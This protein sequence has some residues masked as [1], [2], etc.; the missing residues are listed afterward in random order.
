MSKSTHTKL[1]AEPATTRSLRR[2]TFGLLCIST[3]FVPWEELLI[4]PGFVTGTFLVSSMALGTAALAIL[5]RSRITI[6]PLPL[7]FFGLFV[8]WNFLS[9]LWT[10]DTKATQGTIV[11]YISLLLFTWMLCEFVD[12]K[13]RL[14]TLLRSYLAGCCVAVVMLLE[15]YIVG[16]PTV[17]GDAARHTGGGL[18]PNN[19]ALLI[20]IGIVIAAYMAAISKPKWKSVYWLFIIPATLSVLLTGSRAGTIGLIAAL[21]IVVVVTWSGGAQAVLPLVLALACVIWL[22]PNVVPPDLMQRITEGT[23]AGTFLVR[24]DIWRNGLE[25]WSESPLIGV[26]ARGFL[27]AV[28]ERGGWAFVAHN[29][30]I[31]VLTDTGIV[32]ASLLF[33]AW[34]VLLKQTLNLPRSGRVL[35]LGAALVWLINAAAT[36]L[37]CSKITWLLCGWIMVEYNVFRAT[38]TRIPSVLPVLANEKT[39]NI[40]AAANVRTST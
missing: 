4:I 29:T 1:R 38:S 15:A 32:G 20:S 17:M 7:L 40:S 3:F 25:V 14:L 19:Y 24:Q 27:T 12:S 6:P 8:L 34:L 13:S 33:T 2:A 22:I 31:Q 5:L 39:H 28:V 18:N 37:E 26:G 11:T 10:V 21:V 16:R 35:W 36:S 30:P 9:L 23:G